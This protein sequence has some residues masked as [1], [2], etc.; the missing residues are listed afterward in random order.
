MS[1][2]L[3]AATVNSPLATTIGDR[4]L[5][6]RPHPSRRH[7]TRWPRTATEH[8][9]SRELGIRSRDAEIG[10][11]LGQGRCWEAKS[12]GS[13][14]SC[15]GLVRAVAFDTYPEKNCVVVIRMVGF[16]SCIG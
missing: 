11:S 16:A 3:L 8:S 13:R 2:S 4:H 15:G 1:I 14:C 10:R 5:S 12:L 6:S 9:G 7:V